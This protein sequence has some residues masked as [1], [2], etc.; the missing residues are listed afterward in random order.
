MFLFDEH[1]KN[2][3]DFGLLERHEGALFNLE[4]TKASEL[5]CFASLSSD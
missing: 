3:S 5:F 4:L 2:F 1:A